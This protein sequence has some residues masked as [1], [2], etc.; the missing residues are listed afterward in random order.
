MVSYLDTIP[1]GPGKP[2]GCRIVGDLA[3]ADLQVGRLQVIWPGG[4]FLGLPNT[5]QQIGSL[6]L[7]LNTSA[8]PETIAILTDGQGKAVA[9]TNSSGTVDSM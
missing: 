1:A 9:D 5:A 4:T 3:G 7:E 8:S 6:T 2:A